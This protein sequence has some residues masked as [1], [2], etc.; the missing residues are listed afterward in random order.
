MSL[1]ITTTKTKQLFTCPLPSE[2]QIL[3]WET[4][5]K[6]QILTWEKWRQN[7]THF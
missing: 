6:K 5:S 2:R 4:Y 1:K 7:A 3:T